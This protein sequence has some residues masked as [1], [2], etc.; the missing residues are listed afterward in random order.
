MSGGP[1]LPRFIGAPLSTLCVI[2]ARGG[3]KG[4][5]EKNLRLVNGK[6]LVAHALATVERVPSVSH[7]VVSTDS[8]QIASV[9]R[10]HGGNVIDR[11]PMLAG[12]DCPIAPVIQHAVAALGWSGPVLTFQP[13]CPTLTTKD[14]VEFIDGWQ[15]SACASG[16]MVAPEPHLLW[17]ELGPLYESR[18]QR[19]DNTQHFR[20]LGVFLSAAVPVGPLDPIIGHPHYRHICTGV[21]V[22]SHDDLA[23]AR[24]AL[25]RRQIEFRVLKGPGL[26]H[27]RRCESLAAELAHHECVFVTK[28]RQ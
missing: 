11:P 18:V 8:P 1:S 10:L 17:D 6:P 23:A 13:T 12:D 27:L 3:S 7:I 16:G 22:D 21:D 5:P 24:R 2:P 19:Q 15:L 9:V 25:G 14:L 4:I 26:G 28:E 20:E